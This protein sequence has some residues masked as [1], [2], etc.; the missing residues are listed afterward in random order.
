[1]D[2]PR[3][4]I[5]F[6]LPTVALLGGA[7]VRFGERVLGITGPESWVDW[8]FLVSPNHPTPAEAGLYPALVGSVMLM[9]IVALLAFPVGVGAA[10]Y[11]EEYAPTAGRPGSSR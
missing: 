10:V 7:V 1:V 5:G 11:L 4:H 2:R 8:Q 6:L 9:V 3:E